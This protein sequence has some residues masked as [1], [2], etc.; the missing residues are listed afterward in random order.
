M[1]L[2]QAQKKFSKLFAQLILWSFDKGYEVVL[3]EVFRTPQQAAWYAAKGKG[4]ANSL[5]T[6]CL[7]ADINLFKNGSYLTQ[8]EEYQELGLY[9]ESLDPNCNWGGRFD[10][11]NHFSYSW[12]GMRGIK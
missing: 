4:I 1:T 5:H 7:A 3:G 11:G 10:D 9:W 6:V 8:S 2:G 12:F